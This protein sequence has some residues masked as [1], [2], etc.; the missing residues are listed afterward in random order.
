[1]AVHFHPRSSLRLL[2]SLSIIVVQSFD[3]LYSNILDLYSFLSL[4]F[5]SNKLRDYSASLFK[6]MER[7]CFSEGDH[8][9]VYVLVVEGNG[10]KMVSRQRREFK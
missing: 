6:G 1:M 4:P 5:P 3:A 8:T 2:L 7:E 9:L 10:K